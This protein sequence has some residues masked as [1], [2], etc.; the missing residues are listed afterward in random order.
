VLSGWAVLGGNVNYAFRVVD[1]TSGKEVFVKQ[2]PEF[3]AVFGPDGFPLTSARMQQEMDVYAR[4]R[5]ILGEDQGAAYLPTIYLF[6]RAN[7]VFVMEFLGDCELLD[8][9]MVTSGVVSAEVARGLGQFMG[10]THAATHASLIAPDLAATLT[11]AFENRAMRDVQLAFVF[12]KCYAEAEDA[13]DLRAD[14]AFMAEV[15]AQPHKK[16][17]WDVVACSS[18]SLEDCR[19]LARLT[20]QMYKATVISAPAS[21]CRRSRLFVSAA[22][23]K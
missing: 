6:D 22:F 4:W 17:N 21:Y 12:S 7:M 8:H 13:A 16:I 18:P 11:A 9:T 15:N 20:R 5:A 14:D 10:T 3:V 2:A 23:K 1:N 19:S